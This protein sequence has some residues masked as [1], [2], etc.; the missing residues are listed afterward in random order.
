MSTHPL[1]RPYEVPD[2][3]TTDEAFVAGAEPKVEGGV[4]VVPYDPAWPLTYVQVAQAVRDTVGDG[5]V[6]L[7]HVGS[8]AVPGLAAKPVIDIDLVVA[9]PADETSYVPALERAGFVL[10]I[11]EPEWEQ[12]RMLRLDVPMVNLHVFGPDSRETHRHL[13]FRDRLRGDVADRE[14]YGALKSA[15]AHQDFATV[16]AYNAAKAALI[17]AIYER[18]FAADSEHPHDPRP[19]GA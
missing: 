15:L 10:R 9:D 13:L 8:T 7:A 19:I 2:Q 1:W 12:H 17:Y 6:A 3:E 4:T 18:A 5:V 16:T 11:R 14:A